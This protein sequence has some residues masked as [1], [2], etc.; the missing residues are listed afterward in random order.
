[1]G[2]VGRSLEGQHGD[3]LSLGVDDPVLGDAGLGVVSHLLDRVS[4]GVV[5][6]DDLDNQV[7]A[8]PV[9]VLPTQ[10][11][12]VADKQEISGSRC[13]PGRTCSRSGAKST[14]PPSSVRD[15]RSRS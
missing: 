5:W 15:A 13:L 9:A 8:Q 2:G 1:M 7:G 3:G 11:V 12:G 14:R 10:V 4:L 6:A